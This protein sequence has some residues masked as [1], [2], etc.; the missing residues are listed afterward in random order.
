MLFCLFITKLDIGRR[1]NQDCGTLHNDT[2]HSNQNATFNTTVEGIVALSVEFDIVELWVVRPNV[3]AP[4]IN[5]EA[6]GSN[7]APTIDILK[8]HLFL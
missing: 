1:D 2:R 5:V 8:E 6:W 4:D 7:I 3:V